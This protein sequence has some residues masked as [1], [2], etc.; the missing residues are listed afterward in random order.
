MDYPMTLEQYISTTQ[1]PLREIELARL[2][3]QIAEA[4]AA[5]HQQGKVHGDVKPGNILVMGDGTYRLIGMESVRQYPYGTYPAYVAPEL[6]QGGAY[7]P[8]IDV[9]SLGM[10]MRGLIPQRGISNVFEEL[11][12]KACEPDP[13]KRYTSALAFA[14][15]L[16][17]ITEVLSGETEIL[18]NQQAPYIPAQTGAR[19]N[20]AFVQT[21]PMQANQ[22]Y[23]QTPP[24]QANQGYVQT[25]PMQAN[26][27]YAQTPPMQANQGYAQNPQ[28]PVNSGYSQNLKPVNS[29]TQN[30]AA[31]AQQANYQKPTGDMQLKTKKKGANKETQ[32]AA[33]ALRFVL[34]ILI[35]LIVA[36]A[37]AAWII[38]K[39]TFKKDGDADNVATPAVAEK[40]ADEEKEEEKDKEKET[41]KDVTVPD[42]SGKEESVA[43][44]EL[45]DAGLTVKIEYTTSDTVKKGI[46]MEQ[47]EAAGKT[48]SSD[49][50]VV[51]TVS[52]GNGCP[53]EYSQKITVSARPGSTTGTLTV[54]NWENNTWASK[55]SCACVV[56]KN[57]IGANYGEG[58]GVTPQGTFK[59]GYVM[60]M[61]DPENSMEFKKANSNLG[62][63]DDVNSPLYN[64]MVYVDKVGDVSV[65]HVGENIVS[66]KLNYIIF[67]EHNGNGIS[68]EGVVS[69]KGSVIT[70]CGNN[71]SVS[72]T[73]GCIDI[74]SSDMT[75][76][77]EN[78]DGTKTPYI[79]ITTE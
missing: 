70:I 32:K 3:Q 59:L 15:D 60:G 75:T 24:M 47:S 56:G 77:L 54:Y 14:E 53:Y 46:V 23:A 37:V 34:P 26:Q 13:A 65:D 43:K 22:G 71:N 67:I 28:K 41:V 35:V 21:P 19:P 31:Y 12:Q 58:K 1:T 33:L 48:I 29:I 9:Y 25:P 73:A 4:L 57:G 7:H 63:C 50:E 68:T 11:I 6:M 79:E 27:G 5:I 49:T 52:E 17:M 55:F 76:L 16:Q 72:Q 20:P 8:G 42:L 62:I 45:E 2:G 30:E 66:G 64:I 69:G 61:N 78:L 44:K 18:N 10:M 39:D 40:T 36:A 51:L 38:L 74:T